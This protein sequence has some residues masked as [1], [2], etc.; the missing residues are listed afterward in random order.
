MPLQ[1]RCRRHHNETPL[2][3][4]RLSRRAFSDFRFAR[5]PELRRVNDID[6]LE[7]RP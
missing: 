3:V 7:L 2:I 1:P 6:Y 5:A 4:S